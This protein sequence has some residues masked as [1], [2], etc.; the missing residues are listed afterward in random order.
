MSCRPLRPSE[1]WWNRLGVSYLYLDSI[2]S[3]QPPS[4][5]DNTC[6]CCI[7]LWNPSRCILSE[8]CFGFGSKIYIKEGSAIM[9]YIHCL[10]HSRNHPHY[11]P[12]IISILALFVDWQVLVWACAASSISGQVF[13]H[14]HCCHQSTTSHPHHHCHYLQQAG[15]LREKN[16]YVNLKNQASLLV[17]K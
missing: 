17:K 8:S 5:L 9:P 14:C 16:I 1:R 13:L 7:L 6:V 15:L 12:L 4:Q 3:P 2:P 11:H 10:R